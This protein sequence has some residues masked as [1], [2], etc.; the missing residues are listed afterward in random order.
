VRD[1]NRLRDENKSVLAGQQLLQELTGVLG[2]TL[3]QRESASLI[4]TAPFI[5]LLINLAPGTPRGE[6]I[7]AGG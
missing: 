5:E 4:D 3:K 7:P 6:T 2:F 1:I